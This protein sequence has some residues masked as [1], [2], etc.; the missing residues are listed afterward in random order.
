MMPPLWDCAQNGICA[1]SLSKDYNVLCVC[2]ADS[3]VTHFFGYF[4]WTRDLVVVV[5]GGPNTMH[6][7]MADGESGLGEITV[8]RGNVIGL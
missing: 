6:T 8:C 5:T 7:Q 2:V 3:R 4:G 1:A